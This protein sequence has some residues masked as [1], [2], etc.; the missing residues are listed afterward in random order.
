MSGSAATINA[1]ICCP[2]NK[3]K[4][5]S[6]CFQHDISELEKGISVWSRSQPM[7]YFRCIRNGFIGKLCRLSKDFDQ[8]HYESMRRKL[9]LFYNPK[10]N[11]E[12]F[13]EI[14]DNMPSPPSKIMWK[15]SPKEVLFRFQTVFKK[16]KLE[17]T[18][19]GE[20]LHFYKDGALCDWAILRKIFQH[21]L[22]D[23]IAAKNLSSKCAHSHSPTMVSYEKICFCCFD[24]MGRKPLRSFYTLDGDLWFETEVTFTG[25][26][27]PE[28]LREHK[29]K[30]I[31][32]TSNAK[33]ASERIGGLWSVDG[34]LTF[35]S[36]NQRS[37]CS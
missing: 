8:V 36:W 21:P 27:A 37:K 4:D 18:Y 30:V 29:R 22:A 34:G 24:N 13:R 7:L 31:T 2:R 16:H 11:L 20:S 10:I 32:V 15:E 26:D 3:M 23:I 9:P 35:K 28:F 6:I 12:P 33:I 17:A 14:T 5:F 19:N 25:Y 1:G